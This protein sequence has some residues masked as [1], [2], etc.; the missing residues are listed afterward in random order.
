[1][2]MGGSVNYRLHVY[3][4]HVAWPKVTEKRTGCNLPLV[5]TTF[6]VALSTADKFFN[7]TRKCAFHRKILVSAVMKM[8]VDQNPS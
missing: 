5:L 8:E 6:F 2:E 4:S 7:Y 3:A 1:M